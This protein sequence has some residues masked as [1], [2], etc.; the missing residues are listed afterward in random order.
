MR[1]ITE[2]K[3]RPTSHVT[4]RTRC[5][6]A[7]KMNNVGYYSSENAHLKSNILQCF[8]QNS[9]TIFMVQNLIQNLPLLVIRILIYDLFYTSVRNCRIECAVYEGATRVTSMLAKSRYL[10]VEKSN[11]DIISL[12]NDTILRKSGFTFLT[13][14]IKSLLEINGYLC[15]RFIFI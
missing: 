13:V 3:Y 2:Q 14:H 1:H 15:S 11:K 9:L 5:P 6:S 12:T 7:S 10:S 4:T 8:M